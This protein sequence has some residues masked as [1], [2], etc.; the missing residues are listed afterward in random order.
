MGAPQGPPDARR[1][2][3]AAPIESDRHESIA[4]EHPTGGFPDALALV[5]AAHTPTQLAGGPSLLGHLE[6][7]ASHASA[8][9]LRLHPGHGSYDARGQSPVRGREVVVASADYRQTDPTALNKID[10]RLE[11]RG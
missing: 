6:V 8:P 1:H 3:S 9:V 2:A 5:L 7:L 4:F 10:E 11:L